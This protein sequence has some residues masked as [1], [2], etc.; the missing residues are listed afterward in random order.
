MPR[1]IVKR[2]AVIAAVDVMRDPRPPPQAVVGVVV[3]EQVVAVV[4]VGLEMVASAGGE[5]LE[6]GAVEPAAQHAAADDLRRAAVGAGGLGH[7]LVTDR[8]IK[9]TV[10]ADLRARR[11][12][13][14]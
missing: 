2:I 3:S 12:C 8:D 7:A 5:D 1:V 10:D 9:I 4:E 14:R 11:R 13:G 6:P